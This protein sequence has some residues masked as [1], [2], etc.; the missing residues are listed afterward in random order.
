MFKLILRYTF[1]GLFVTQFVVFVMLVTKFAYEDIPF[2][3]PLP[4][5]TYFAKDLIIKWYGRLENHV[6]LSLAV[7]KDVRFWR[8]PGKVPSSR[9][10][11]ILDLAKD[12]FHHPAVRAPW[13]ETSQNVPRASGG[14]SFDIMM[15][16]GRAG[17]SGNTY[18]RLDISEATLSGAAGGKPKKAKRTGWRR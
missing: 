12:T 2:F 6:P 13:C 4:I 15:L 17:V 14:N 10:G 8:G 18:D 7:A 1:T 3:L 11:E 16:Q 9:T 5:A